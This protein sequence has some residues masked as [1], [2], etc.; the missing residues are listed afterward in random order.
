MTINIAHLLVCTRV[1]SHRCTELSSGRC[2]ARCACCWILVSDTVR[3][4]GANEGTVMN[5]HVLNAAEHGELN[6]C[7]K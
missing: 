2:V 6:C 3:S 4:T 1:F 5:A 7:R